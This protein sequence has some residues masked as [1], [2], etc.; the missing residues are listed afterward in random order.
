LKLKGEAFDKF[1]AYKVLVEN[2]IGMKIKTLQSDNGGEFV[3]KKFDKFL[4]ECG[5][6]RQTSAAYTPQENGV[7]KQTNRTIMECV[8]NMIR[9]QGLDLEFWVEAVH[10]T[11]YIKNRCTTK[12]LDLK[13][14]QEAWT[15]IKHDVSHLRV[16]GCKTYATFL[17]KR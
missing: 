2:Q 8:R 5:I 1:K 12:A 17:M 10:T 14:P 7:A 9:A 15:G 16:F 6:Q 11:V 4:H 3:S 13:T